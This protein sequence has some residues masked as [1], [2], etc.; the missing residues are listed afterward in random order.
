VQQSPICALGLERQSDD[1]RCFRH[2]RRVDSFAGI[3]ADFDC[4]I[5]TEWLRVLIGVLLP[6]LTA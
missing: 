6:L 5:K 1:H 4:A 3:A 2:F